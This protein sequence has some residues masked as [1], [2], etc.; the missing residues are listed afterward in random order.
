M[1]RNAVHSVLEI[2]KLYIEKLARLKALKMSKIIKEEQWSLFTNYRDPKSG[3]KRLMEFWNG[4]T[5]TYWMQLRPAAVSETK[6]QS[7]YSSELS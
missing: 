4:K 7:C 6:I 3:E 5:D 2:I 1:G